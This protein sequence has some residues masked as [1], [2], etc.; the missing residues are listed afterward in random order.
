L[1]EQFNTFLKSKGYD[2]IVGTTPGAGRQW[3]AFH[4][5]QVKSINNIG[6]FDPTDIR[7]MHGGGAWATGKEMSGVEKVFRQMPEP[8]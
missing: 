7:M 1:A 5:E 4:P 2:G 3:V 8:V 6:T